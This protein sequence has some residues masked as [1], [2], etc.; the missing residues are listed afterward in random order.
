MP[1]SKLKTTLTREIALFLVLLFV[2]IV[3]APIGIF[4]VGQQIFGEF[5]GYGYSEFFGT[6]SAKLRRGEAVTWFFV[7]SPY[8]LWQTLRL[9]LYGWRRSGRSTG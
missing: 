7:L 2:G 6:I 8:L 5:G 1:E 4:V 9:T 3:I